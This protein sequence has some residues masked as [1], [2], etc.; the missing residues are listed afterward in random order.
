MQ[1]DYTSKVSPKSKLISEIYD[2]IENL[3]LAVV[4]VVFVFVFIARLSIVSGA[5]MERT[6]QDKD[7]LV[8]SNPFFTYDPEAGDIV[9]IH[10]DK[11]SEPLVKRVIATE[12]QEIIIKYCADLGS[13]GG[14]LYDIYVDGVLLDEEYAF[15]DDRLPFIE[16]SGEVMEIHRVGNISTAKATVPEGCVFVL[17]DNRN[18][19]KDSR[20]GQVGFINENFILGKCVFRIL[21]AQK[22]GSLK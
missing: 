7:Y 14:T 12:G 13:M 10:T 16:P 11:Y 5:S 9:V 21:P 19:S 2:W 18:N 6:L 4:A 3:V 15:Y 1:D 20:S 17:G 8:V 22:F